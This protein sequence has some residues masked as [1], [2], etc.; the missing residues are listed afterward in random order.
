MV[1]PASHCAT[2]H[3]ES[4][5]FQVDRCTGALGGREYCQTFAQR[6]NIIM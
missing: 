5:C 4:H 1:E 3:E 6:F 2:T